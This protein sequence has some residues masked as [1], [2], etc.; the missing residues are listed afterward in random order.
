MCNQV[1]PFCLTQLMSCILNNG[2]PF[3]HSEKCVYSTSLNWSLNS[4][5]SNSIKMFSIAHTYSIWKTSI[6]DL[7]VPWSG[8][9]MFFYSVV[10]P[11]ESSDTRR[12][13]YS[14]VFQATI[15]IWATRC[16]TKWGVPTK[17]VFWKSQKAPKYTDPV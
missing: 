5:D 7:F 4:E 8:R 14:T 1:V 3:V 12:H 17:K 9:I 10:V 6:K 16:G 13:R 2:S 15:S 11:G